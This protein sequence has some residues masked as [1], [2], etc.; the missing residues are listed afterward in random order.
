LLVERGRLGSS[1]VFAASGGCHTGTGRGEARGRGGRATRRDD[2][3]RE[4]GAFVGPY[5]VAS[6]TAVLVS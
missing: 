3:Q 6:C 4:P 5:L 2:F 1:V